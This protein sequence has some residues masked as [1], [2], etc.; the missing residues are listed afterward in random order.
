MPTATIARM[1]TTTI[2]FFILLTP[3][4]SYHGYELRFQ[5]PSRITQMNESHE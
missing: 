3:S 1:I 4:Y 2:T 5:V